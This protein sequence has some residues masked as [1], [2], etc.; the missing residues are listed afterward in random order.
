MKRVMKNAEVDEEKL[1]GF[2]IMIW[3]S[4]MALFILCGVYLRNY[5]TLFVKMMQLCMLQDVDKSDDYTPS[6]LDVIS[7]CNLL[8]V[9]STIILDILLVRDLKRIVFSE[10]NNFIK[11]AIRVPI[12][13]TL[14]STVMFG[15]IV[16]ALFASKLF[17]FSPDTLR[18]IK[19][20]TVP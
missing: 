20:N 8:L 9:V 13:A 5:N 11:E 10:D 2:L 3:L 14:L 17:S 12:R 19:I 4:F 16:F 6:G 1:F 18:Y 7:I 15:L